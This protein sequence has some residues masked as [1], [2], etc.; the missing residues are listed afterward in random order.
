[1]IIK[2][3]DSGML[4][5]LIDISLFRD[6]IE[7]D[8]LILTPNHRLAA[9]IN[10]AWALAVEQSVWRAPRVYSID[11]WLR[12]CWDELQDQNHSL[13]SGLSI[14]GPQQSRYYWERAI[15]KDDSA[16]TNSYAK[17]SSYAK[18]ASDTLKTLQNWNL[19]ADQVPGETPAVEYF[20]RWTASFE[21]LLQR[22]KLITQQTAW[23]LV[24]QGFR[25][26]ALSTEAEI[27]LY[28][29]QST[30]PLQSS[31]IESA[32]NSL[33]SLQSTA[34]AASIQSYHRLE[35][36]DS[37]T[38]LR[39]AT[40]WAAQQLKADPNQRLGIIIPDLNNSLQQVAR[41]TAE[42]LKSQQSEMLVNISA[43]TPLAE[44]A[45]V[46]RAL[47]LIGILQYKR[48]LN[49]WLQLLYSPFSAFDQLPLQFRVDSELALRKTRRFDFTLEQFLSAILPDTSTENNSPD[50]NKDKEQQKQFILSIL[51]PLIDLKT[52]SR[53]KTGTQK[54]FSAW[55][56]FFNQFLND[57]GWPGTRSLNSMEYQQRQHW[58]STIEQFCTLDNLAIE[59]GLAT[60]LKHL[61]QLAQESVFHPKTADAPLQILGLLEGSGLRF[62]QL[63]IV[64]MH[65]QNFPASVAINPLLPADFQRQHAMPHSLPERELQI[66]QE[67]LS[68]YKNNS[69]R[70]I[71]SYPLMRGEE[72]LDPSPLIRDIPVSD[73][74]DILVEPGAQP[75]WLVQAEQCE[76]A[77]DKAP[78][79]NPARENIYGGSKLLENQAICPFNAFATHRLKA[80]PLEEPIQ[81]LSAMDRGS[82]IHEILYRLWSNWKSST[83][84]KSVPEQQLSEQ[85]AT[86]IAE[87]LTE[88]APRHAVLRGNRF[89][90]LEQ[91]R[92]EKL[93]GQ[94]LDEEKLRQPFEVVNLESSA[95]IRFGDLNISLRLDRVDQIGDKRLVI[96]YKT[97][98]VKPKKWTEERPTEPQL[99]LYLLAS[100][101][102]ANGC[103]FAQ[104]RAGDIKFIGSS[105]SQL[106]SFEKPADNWPAQIDQ[107]QLSL[108]SLASEFTSGYI[109]VE[110][111]DKTS[112]GFQDHLLPLNRWPEEPEVN[113]IVSRQVK[114]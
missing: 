107:W 1:M 72:A 60:A 67:L 112:F 49:D 54:S 43:G 113:A 28:G 16:Q 80:E 5:P 62:D 104:L 110:V 35:C 95:S 94:W 12:Y 61:Q 114:S 96:D 14:V 102:Q 6:A 13:V 92:L 81:G 86:V 101:P 18:I 103:A 84:L 47:E 65:S 15:A 31:V 68:D 3:V 111:H 27:Q 75:P 19:S 38:E 82:L 66:A 51:Q 83:F 109:S 8:C 42:A 21:E 56:G 46:N 74:A 88:W 85:V 70:L 41:V 39:N 30:P 45:I 105:D 11:H 63:W 64:G 59:V 69:Q 52:Y 2:V 50:A 100:S 22:N 55:A 34:V 99:P 53:I 37:Q 78:A 20:K 29:F 4:P 25:T 89:R 17:I 7:R 58:D 23:Q 33:K 57:M 32:S 10:D 26:G 79:Y 93:I 9:K 97:G 108:S 40:Q 77:L 73:S 98:L 44:T 91:Q 87:T 36:Q 24:E 76:L 90:A 106:I 71:L 48:P